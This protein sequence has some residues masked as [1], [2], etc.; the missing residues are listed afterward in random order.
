M[1]CLDS[2]RVAEI[3]ATIT[4]LTANLT[5]INAA[6]T[7][8]TLHVKSYT[9][10][11]GEARQMTTYRSLEDLFKTRDLIRSQIDTLNR[12]LRGQGLVNL[13]VRRG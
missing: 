6:I 8:G 4:V 11:T 1:G 10:D 12:K 2:T 7:S 5:A 9:L 13:N 3:Q